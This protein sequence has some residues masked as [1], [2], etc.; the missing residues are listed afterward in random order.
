MMSHPIVQSLTLEIKEMKCIR[1][2]SGF[3]C[4]TIAMD[5]QGV[6]VTS[7]MSNKRQKGRQTKRDRQRQTDK[8]IQTD[9]QTSK[10][11]QTD[12]DMQ[13]DRQTNKDIQTDK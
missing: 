12:K 4:R 13:T 3:S 2:R 5:L 7:T 10:Y 11:R 1:L 9:R 6:V 8:G